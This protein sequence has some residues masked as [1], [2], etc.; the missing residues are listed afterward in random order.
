MG[1]LQ[2]S[3]AHSNLDSVDLSER[4]LGGMATTSGGA[5]EFAPNGGGL[6]EMWDGHSWRAGLA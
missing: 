5:S 2:A 3:A 1:V 6:G 4:M